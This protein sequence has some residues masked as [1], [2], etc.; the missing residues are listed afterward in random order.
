MYCSK[1][2]KQIDDGENFCI[3]CGNALNDQN[4]SD[5]VQSGETGINNNVNTLPVSGQNGSVTVPAQAVEAGNR[6]GKSKGIIAAVIVVL[7]AAGVG[8]YLCFGDGGKGE[9]FKKSGSVSTSETKRENKETQPAETSFS[10][11]SAESVEN[12]TSAETSKPDAKAVSEKAKEKINKIL[13]DKKEKKTSDKTSDDPKETSPSR[14]GAEDEDTSAMNEA[15]SYSTYDKPSFEEF[16]WCYGQNGLVTSPPE[17]AEPITNAWGFTGGWKAMIV[18]NDGSGM[19]EID[20]CM[21]TMSDDI[22]T[23]TM[24]WYYSE[25]LNSEGSSMEDM[26]D[27]VFYGI[28]TGGGLAVDGP[29]AI[30]LNHFWKYGGKEYS[31]GTV[32]TASGSAAYIALVR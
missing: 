6:K 32:N 13:K 14:S 4:R 19:R 10:E 24:D 18:Y 29:S 26:D 15:L 22:I 8:M 17:K 20:N 27:T 5:T 12:V 7:A 30:T 31:V 21:I 23:L 11:T 25:V 2:G 16:E 28:S 3:Y 9:K 1:C